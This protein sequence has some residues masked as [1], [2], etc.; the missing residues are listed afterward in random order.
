MTM[1]LASVGDEFRMRERQ[2]RELENATL[3]LELYIMNENDDMYA[4]I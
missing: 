1:T 2:R 4:M 3:E